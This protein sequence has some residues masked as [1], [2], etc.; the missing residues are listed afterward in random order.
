MLRHT[1]PSSEVPQST[2]PAQRDASGAAT[3]RR[4]TISSPSW[5]LWLLFSINVV[6]YLDR[7][8]AVAVGP[9]LKAQFHL[10]D[11]SIGL[12]S[13]AFLIVYTLAT[14]PLGVLADRTRR[15]RIVAA[16]VAVWS[17]LSAATSLTRGYVGLFLTRA[18]VGVGEASYFPAGQALL[19]AY[20]PLERRA[21]AMGRWGSG[22]IVGAA[23]AFI[24]SAMLDHWLGPAIGWRVAFVVAALPG[25]A[26][27][28]LMWR[29][30]DAPPTRSAPASDAA[31]AEQT[32]QVEQTE[33]IRRAASGEVLT[34]VVKRV[35]QVLDIGTVRLGI[36]L[37]A[38]IY[39]VVTPTVT[40]LPIYL[41]SSQSGYHLGNAQADLLSGAV[42]VVGGL[43][44]TLL[45]GYYADWLDRRARGGRLLAVGTA[46]AAGL[47]C[48]VVMLLTH[49]LPVFMAVGT[50][51]VLTLN[52]QVGP[53]GAVVQ[54][55]TPAH[56]RSSAV[57]V[58]LVI[59]HLLGDSWSPTAVGTLSTAMGERTALGLLWVGAPAL[60]LA[61][62]VGTVGARIYASDVEARAH[63][64]GRAQA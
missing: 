56:L 55:A 4:W 3:R 62:V 14:I 57:A 9:T 25:L 19:S 23:L 63:Q 15:A 54:D 22:Q 60:L 5:V 52:L 8:L 26:L 50:L 6:N 47:P 51:A 31:P 59:A 33:Q 61:A 43:A 53:L 64:R 10:T 45:G 39:I 48:Y 16:G 41:R 2:R 13:S 30:M 42:I 11:S 27:A 46:C 40:F 38:F 1:D 21:R 20:Y 18:G 58:G 37:Q 35:R 24:L 34:D 44:G 7:L 36:A 17:V 12:L 49:S 28:V 29:V 32:E